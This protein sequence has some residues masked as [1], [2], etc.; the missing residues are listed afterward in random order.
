MLS[1]LNHQ[2]AART[3]NADCRSPS[4][5]L[6]HSPVVPL[7]PLKTTKCASDNYRSYLHSLKGIIA[8]FGRSLDLAMQHRLIL[9]EC[10]VNSL[11]A[12]I[13]VTRCRE[14]PI[15]GECTGETDDDDNRGISASTHKRSRAD[16][17][18]QGPCDVTLAWGMKSLQSR[19]W[20]PAIL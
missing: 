19:E 4:T 20:Q 17:R 1:R 14:S 15:G 7:Q 12:S 5:S 13:A 3:A 16:L 11:L 18:R 8:G 6:P 9:S 2:D 10:A